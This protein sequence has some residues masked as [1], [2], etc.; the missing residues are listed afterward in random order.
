MNGEMKVW[1]EDESF[2]KTFYRYMFSE[3]QFEK[4]LT[5]VDQIIQ[6]VGFKGTRILDLCC[7][8]GRFTLPLAR[9]GYHVT[10]VDRTPFLLDKAKKDAVAENLDI[11]FVLQDMRDFVRPNSF[12]MALSIF[13]SFGYF[14]DKDDDLKVLQNIFLSLKPGGFLVLEIFGKE[15]LA[16]T[17]RDSH[18]EEL[19]D[20]SVMLQRHEIFENWTRIRNE[21]ILIK[22][23]KARSFRFH[24]T[25]YSGQELVDRFEAAGFQEIR[26]FGNFE[27]VP[28]GPDAE[29]L[30]V[31]GQKLIGE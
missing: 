9:K 28:Y 4:A 31:I 20:G 27:G 14:D 25:I 23:G 11:E 6:L 1:F 13:T 7:G 12:E 8:P 19:E 15:C 18:A 24:H 10:G 2:W 26:V 3:K 30:V 22:G 17:F 5:Q 21:W 16:R 29:R